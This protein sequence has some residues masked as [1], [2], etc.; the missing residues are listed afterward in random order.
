MIL[1]NHNVLGDGTFANLMPLLTGLKEWEQPD[2]DK[3]LLYC[4]CTG[5]KYI[6]LY[7]YFVNVYPGYLYDICTR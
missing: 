3:L 7:R 2:I 5:A 4:T 1:R 6:V